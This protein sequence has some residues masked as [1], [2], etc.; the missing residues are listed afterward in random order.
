MKFLNSLDRH[1][2]GSQKLLRFL[3]I[4][5]DKR[6]NAQGIRWI[7]VKQNFFLPIFSKIK[8]RKISNP[9]LNSVLN[10]PSIKIP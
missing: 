8:K 5:P 7:K 9:L 3:I 2:S 4:C 1:F 10:H 6:G